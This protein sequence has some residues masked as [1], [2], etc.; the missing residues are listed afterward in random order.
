[1]QRHV[2]E[3]EAGLEDQKDAIAAEKVED[4]QAIDV[5]GTSEIKIS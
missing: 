2:H 5:H 3:V 4:T 1:M